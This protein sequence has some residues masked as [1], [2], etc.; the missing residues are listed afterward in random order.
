[1]MDFHIYKDE[2]KYWINCVMKVTIKSNLSMKTDNFC[3]MPPP[4]LS[5]L[6]IIMNE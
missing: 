6:W 5:V 1:M 3:C 4:L 2:L